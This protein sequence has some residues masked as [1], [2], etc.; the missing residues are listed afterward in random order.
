MR[1]A[2]RTV[3]IE[4]A[5]SADLVMRAMEARSAVP[6]HVAVVL[7]LEPGGAGPGELAHLLRTRAAGIPRLR[8]RLVPVPPGCGRPVWVDVPQL[9]A[10][11]HLRYL[12]CPP[13]WDEPALLGLVA[14]LVGERLP[15][16]RP[17]WAAAVVP[18]LA[19]GR[20]G[21]VLVVHHVVA[22]GLGGQAVLAG[23]LDPRPGD[24]GPAVP[25]PSTPQA[26]PGWG[27]L[28]ADA[29]R[30]D[31]ARLGQLPATWRDLRRSLRA[32]GGL[33]AE[34]AARCSLLARTGGATRLAVARTDLAAIRAAAHRHGATVNDAVLAAVGGAL[35]TVLGK[36]GET[37]DTVR[38]AVMV[39]ARRTAA[40][41]QLGN[42]V[43]PLLVD[44]PAGGA[45]DDRLR[46]VAGRVARA[47]DQ[48]TGPSV[49]TVLGPA[50]R[51]AARAGL[52]Q[53]LMRHQRRMHTLVSDVTGPAAPVTLGGRRVA[54]MTP[55][56]VGESGNITLGFVVLSYAGVLT[57]TVVGDSRV[58]DLPVLA[59]AL[60]AELDALAGPAARAAGR[61]RPT[62]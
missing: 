56:A 18:G 6:Q 40:P 42:Q 28:A 27:S 32:A 14:E 10:G 1:P 58:G 39:S 24:G 48:A 3:P 46:Q 2:P 15:T 43:T 53:L 61:P 60:Q 25:A 23:L 62:A 19:G 55:V 4:R 29:L 26:R 45:P 13:P 59:G 17:L 47:R 20:T 5:S 16:D 8:Q 57:V 44:V 33:R 38:V 9:D 37:V 11:A 35:G 21:V 50:F 41:D 30:A 49:V 22:D 52:H 7:L 54:A 12:P 34:P 31:R 51:W 36:R